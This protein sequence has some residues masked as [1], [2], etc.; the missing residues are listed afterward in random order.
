M[1]NTIGEFDVDGGAWPPPAKRAELAHARADELRLRRADLASGVQTTS[2]AAALA[3]RRAAQAVERAAEAW[4]AAVYRHVEAQ[5][6][7]LRAAAAHE[8]AAMTVGDDECD[9]H[10]SAAE[11]HRSAAAF[12]GDTVA[13]LSAIEPPGTAVSRRSPSAAVHR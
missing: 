11:R 7:H 6:A 12:H 4:R 1:P 9:M 5:Q 10:Q 3:Q 13:E 2:D 8:Q